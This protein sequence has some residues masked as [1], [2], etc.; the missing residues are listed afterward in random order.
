[1]IEQKLESVIESTLGQKTM[2]EAVDVIQQLCNQLM[3]QTNSLLQ[4]NLNIW[5]DYKIRDYAN[6]VQCF[7]SII[8]GIM[9][10]KRG[11]NDFFT[12]K[13]GLQKADEL[14]NSVTSEFNVEFVNAG[15][16]RRGQI[17]DEILLPHF[18]F[19]WFLR[20]SLQEII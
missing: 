19:K 12:I 7:S 9:S 17:I 15:K 2:N 18:S 20:K 11:E 6:R 13:I 8:S 1:M 10:I 4:N 5:S 3:I 14:Y 16:F